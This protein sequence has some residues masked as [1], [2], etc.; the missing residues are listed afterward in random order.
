MDSTPLKGCVVIGNGAASV[1][2]S[3]FTQ[4]IAMRAKQLSMS[5]SGSVWIQNENTVSSGGGMIRLGVSCM[6]FCCGRGIWRCSY[7]G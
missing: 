7:G 3:G 4:S 5:G 2:D 1:S 6:V